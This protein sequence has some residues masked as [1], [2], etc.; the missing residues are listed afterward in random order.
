MQVVGTEVTTFGAIVGLRG[1]GEGGDIDGI[2]LL[3]HI[4]NPGILEPIGTV[5]G[6]AFIGDDDEVAVGQGQAGVRATT[7]GWAPVAVREQ[8]RFGGIAHVEH[9]QTTIA[10]GTVGGG[11]GD[12]GVMQGVASTGPGGSFAARAPHAGY[13]PASNDLWMGEVGKVDDDKDV[14]GIA[15]ERGGGIILFND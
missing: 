5:V 3:A 15:G 11:A 9:G 4:D 2:A 12:D 13:P 6:N 7:E 14:I 1:S 10:P 8:R